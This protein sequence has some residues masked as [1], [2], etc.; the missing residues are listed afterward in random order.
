MAIDD[1]E[2]AF[3]LRLAERLAGPAAAASLIGEGFNAWV[4]R[5]DGPDA[6][7]VVKLGKPHRT[8]ATAEEFAKE[9]WC[10]GVV[11]SVG[12]ATPEALEVGRFED[13]PYLL[14]AFAPGRPP[15]QEER[16]AVWEAFGR[17][18]AAYHALPVDGFGPK[19]AAPGRFGQSWDEHLAYNI[20]SLSPEDPLTAMGVIDPAV[21]PLVKRRFE[22]LAARPW[23]TGLVHADLAL[24]NVLVGEAGEITLLDWGCARGGPVPH[25]EVTEMIRDGRDR[26]GAVAGFARGYGLD[27]AATAA[28]Q[29]DLLDFLLLREIDTLRWALERSPADV[30]ARTRRAVEAMDRLAALG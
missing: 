13:R 15:T 11:R 5:L 26:P 19:L 24:W 3:V 1:A 18:A 28:L 9:L 4:Y 14:L 12:V 30:P 8:A 7:L 22:T 16:P 27:A 21:R 6:P 23:R 20:D 17:F 29:D 25:Q 10:A 2:R